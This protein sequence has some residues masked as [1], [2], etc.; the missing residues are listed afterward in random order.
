VAADQFSERMTVIRNRF[1]SR[2]STKIDD[3]AAELQALSGAGS[4]VIEV[5][6]A[7]Y[8]RIHEICGTAA[9][10]GFFETD[11]AARDIEAILLGPFRARRGLTAD[12]MAR[13]DKG[14]DALRA[15]AQFDKSSTETNTERMP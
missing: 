5:V 1:A 7:T 2:L 10:L 6:V 14:L 13:L 11:L 3:T 12:E 8:H 15:A 4:G 9:T